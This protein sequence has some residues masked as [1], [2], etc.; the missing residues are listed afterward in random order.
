MRM[1]DI[2]AICP[3]CGRANDCQINGNMK[4]W[5]FDVPADKTMLEQ[6]LKDKSKD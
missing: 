3:V 2:G 1:E 5:C 6:A 4:C